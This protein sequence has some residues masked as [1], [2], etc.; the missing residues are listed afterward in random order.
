MNYSHGCTSVFWEDPDV[1]LG[2]KENCPELL[3]WGVGMGEGGV[4]Q[5]LLTPSYHQ[6]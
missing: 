3:L 4:G 2:F 5:C 6:P 1:L